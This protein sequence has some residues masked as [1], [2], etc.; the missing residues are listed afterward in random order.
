[1]IFM[2]GYRKMATFI[3][4]LSIS[5]EVAVEKLPCLQTKLQ[6]DV[7]GVVPS[8]SEKTVALLLVLPCVSDSDIDTIE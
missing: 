6:A 4:D 5:R 7:V 2:V 3:K 8:L 1:M